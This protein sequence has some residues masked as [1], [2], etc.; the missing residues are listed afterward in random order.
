MVQIV[1]PIW[2]FEL[3]QI[4]FQMISEKKIYDFTIHMNKLNDFRVNRLIIC[5]SDQAYDLT[6][7]SVEQTHSLNNKIKHIFV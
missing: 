3:C 6:Q 1:P 5:F 2:R 4:D 7:T